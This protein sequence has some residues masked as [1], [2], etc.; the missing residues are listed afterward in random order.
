MRI[1][2]LRDF[3]NGVDKPLR[4]SSLSLEFQSSTLTDRDMAA[5]KGKMM[6]I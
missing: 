2:T 3:S 5:C 6:R 4:A 1:A